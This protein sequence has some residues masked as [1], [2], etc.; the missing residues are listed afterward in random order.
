M[1]HLISC[2]IVSCKIG[3]MRRG[4]L[5]M[6]A[7]AVLSGAISATS[8]AQEMSDVEFKA[9]KLSERVYLLEA[10]PPI[11]G[12]LAV[13]VGEDGILLVD[14]Q[15]MP[16]TPKIKAAIAKIQQGKIAFLI[17]SHYHFDHAGGNEAFGGETTIVAHHNVRKRLKEGRE[18]GSRFIEGTRPSAALPIITFDESV[19]FHWNGEEVDVIH[20]PDPS[21]TD[22]DSV[23]FFRGSNVIHTGDQYVNVGGFPYIDRDVGGSALG[24]RDNIAELLNIVDDETKIIPGHGPLASK[25]DLQ[26][27]H[28][29]VAQTIEYIEGAKRAGKTLEEIQNS[30]LP[31]KF[32]AAGKSG[33]IPESVWIQSVYASLEP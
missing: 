8:S 12:N 18:A 26:W 1:K 31:Q 28:D 15:M 32:E 29:L 9:T 33:F 19:T 6:V 16:L 22:G 25:A 3:R 21:H 20:F 23:I 11:A 5:L 2:K 27:F 24:L 4:P 30:G 13:F 14:D 10:E 7:V 17:N